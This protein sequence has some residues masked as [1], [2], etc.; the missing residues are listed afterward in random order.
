VA[1][2]YYDRLEFTLA[3]LRKL[4]PIDTITTIKKQATQEQP[5][6][7]RLRDSQGA[8]IASL[9]MTRFQGLIERRTN[10]DRSNSWG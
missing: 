9:R 8:R 6:V 7:L 10:N 5:Q 4:T 3:D 2:G 1:P